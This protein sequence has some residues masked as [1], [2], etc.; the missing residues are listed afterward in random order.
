MKKLLFLI[1]ALPFLS[2][3]QKSE[4]G[5]TGGIGINGKAS[6]NM[7]FLGDKSGSNYATSIIYVSNIREHLQIGFDM[8]MH[9]LSSKSASANYNW[10]GYPIPKGDSRKLE[11][12]KIAASPSFIANYKLKIA[13]D[14]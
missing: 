3:A 13:N 7:P 8:Y 14:A 4:I 10:Q 5:I 9:E 6:S 11:Y 1:V 2:S 12:A